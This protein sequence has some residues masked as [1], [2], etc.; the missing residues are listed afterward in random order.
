MPTPQR[1]SDKN[2]KTIGYQSTN[3][4]GKTVIQDSHCRNLG[5]YN[6][7]NNTTYDQN[8]KVIGTGNQTTRLIK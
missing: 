1:L 2:G 8:G 5:T 7:K 4:H 6:P 3:V